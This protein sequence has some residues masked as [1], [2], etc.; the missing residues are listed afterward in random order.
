MPRWLVQPPRY[1]ECR[2]QCS[3]F[4]SLPLCR[5]G[6]GSACPPPPRHPEVRLRPCTRLTP[7]RYCSSQ[8]HAEIVRRSYLW[9]GATAAAGALILGAV[10]NR[11]PH[12]RTRGIHSCRRQCS[13]DA[14]C[15][16]LLPPSPHPHLLAASPKSSSMGSGKRELNG[17]VDGGQSWKRRGGE[18]GRRGMGK[19]KGGG[20]DELG[21]E[22]LE[23]GR[24]QGWEARVQN[25]SGLAKEWGAG[26]RREEESGRADSRTASVREGQSEGEGD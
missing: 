24:R 19:L 9:H 10:D 1:A 13:C 22:R 17:Q 5:P 8:V 15:S 12:Q 23:A 18:A 3:M 2:P 20:R 7:P 14:P 21:C 25:S 4:T 26:N 16:I 6:P 11:R